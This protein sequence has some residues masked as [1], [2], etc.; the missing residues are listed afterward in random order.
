MARESK[1][2]TLVKFEERMTNYKDE[3][4]KDQSTK[5]WEF[6]AYFMEDATDFSGTIYSLNIQL[7]KYN[8]E[9]GAFEM[10]NEYRLE[11]AARYVEFFNDTNLMEL[12]DLKG[13]EFTLFVDEGR[14]QAYIS[15]GGEFREYEKVG[16]DEDG[17]WLDMV[18]LQPVIRENLIEFSWERLDEE[19]KRTGRYYNKTIWLKGQDEEFEDAIERRIVL[20]K[21]IT[22]ITGG[23]SMNLKALIEKREAKELDVPTVKLKESNFD[24]L[25]KK[26]LVGREV[27]VLVKDW[28]FNG[29][30]GYFLDWSSQKINNAYPKEVREIPEA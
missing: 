28:T 20:N 5:G 16:A 23:K 2:L 17:E 1:K 12:G 9:K 11:Q 27:S 26:Y 30:S 4:G 21:M 6:G 10:D 25:T 8:E 18:Y 29:D 3:K 13:Q 14:E 19:G 15:E 24:E 22:K 7:Q